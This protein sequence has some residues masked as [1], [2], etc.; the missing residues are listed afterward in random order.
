MKREEPIPAS[1]ITA[2]KKTIH[3]IMLKRVRSIVLVACVIFMAFS[4]VDHHLFPP[5][6]EFRIL[7]VRIFVSTTLIGLYLLTFI[8]FI[9][10]HIVWIVDTGILLVVAFLCYVVYLTEGASGKYYEG[11]IQGM[12]VWLILNAFYYKHLL[13]LGAMSLILYASA[14]LANSTHWDLSKFIY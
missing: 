4:F 7:I 10:E 6:Q 1:V 12:F 14:C 8:D 2:Y 3:T 13:F 11:I 9:K 5:D